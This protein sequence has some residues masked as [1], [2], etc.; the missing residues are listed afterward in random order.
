MA[1]LYLTYPGTVIYDKKC[2]CGFYYY[3]NVIV[4]FSVI[5]NYSLKDLILN[6]FKYFEHKLNKF[7][8][9]FMFST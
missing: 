2:V 7:R 6:F 4:I 8:I 3:Q 5:P 9:L 1:T